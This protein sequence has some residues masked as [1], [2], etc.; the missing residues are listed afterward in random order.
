[1]DRIIL[2]VIPGLVMEAVGGPGICNAGPKRASGPGV[3]IGP[4]GGPP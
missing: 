3:S 4:G 2:C 1:M